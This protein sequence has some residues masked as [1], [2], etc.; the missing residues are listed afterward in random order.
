MS[1]LFRH[2][3]RYERSDRNP[4]KL[5]RMWEEQFVEENGKLR[6]REVKEMPSPAT[7][8]TSAYDHEARF[9]TNRGNRGLATKCTLQRA[10]TMIFRV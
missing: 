3:M 10:A 4:I 7:L 8:I 9:S 5:E 6:F 1:A 2:A